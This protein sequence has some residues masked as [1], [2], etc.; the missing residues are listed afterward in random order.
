MTQ[1]EWPKCLVCDKYLPGEDA[2][3]D[4][5]VC[6]TCLAKQ[7]REFLGMRVVAPLMREYLEGVVS[8]AKSTQGKLT[9]YCEC[10]KHMSNDD[11]RPARLTEEEFNAQGRGA[12]YGEACRAYCTRCLG[13]GCKPGVPAT[14]Q[15]PVARGIDNMPAA[16]RKEYPIASGVLDYFPLALAEI[17]HV[18]YVGNEQHNP[19][20][21]THWDRSKSGDEADALMRHFL[22][23]G[24]RDTDGLRH[25]AKMAWR[26]LALLQKELEGAAA[27]A[28]LGAG[29]AAIQSEQCEWGAEHCS[30]YRPARPCCGCGARAG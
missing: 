19:G 26:A 1:S 4:R 21:P 27:M 17:A 28:E 11:H 7:A 24:T 18:S 13:D 12:A 15:A 20:T 5:Y 3:L 16:E 22:T 25:S 2:V 14:K 9:W 6:R 29:I 23:R 8:Q 10:K 30:C